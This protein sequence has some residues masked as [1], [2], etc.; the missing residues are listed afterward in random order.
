MADKKISELT[1][2]TTVNTVDYF[3]FVQG[4]TTQKL[5]FATLLT[6]LPIDTVVV[7]AAESPVSGAIAT[8][9][10]CSLVTSSSGATNYTLVTGTHGMKKLIAVQTI[11]ASATAVLTVTGGA[12]FSTI[13]F[14]NAGQSAELENISGLWYVKS[15][16]GAIAV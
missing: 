5:D 4:G 2:A 16:R 15:I 10:R 13:T 14:S 9:K 1:S 6:N 12:G 7:Q 3:P 8:S 11:G